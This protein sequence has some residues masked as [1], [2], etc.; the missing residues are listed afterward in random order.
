MYATFKIKLTIVVLLCCALVFFYFLQVSSKS[1]AKSDAISKVLNLAEKDVKADINSGK[2]I[3][4]A[5]SRRGVNEIPNFDSR[6]HGSCASD[7]A[8]IRV[9]RVYPDEAKLESLE[10]KLKR[11]AELPRST[12]EYAFQ[13][14]HLMLE[15]LEKQG[16][17]QCN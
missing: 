13:Y 3:L 8:T 2:I 14:N 6:F 12:Y 5:N 1:E 4:L 16:K 7:V 15:H 17:L 9:S 10:Q 11:Y